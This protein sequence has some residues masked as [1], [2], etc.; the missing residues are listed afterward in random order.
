[1]KFAINFEN[2]G[3]KH[4]L[5]VLVAYAIILF[6]TYSPSINAPL[7]YD[8]IPIIR[9]NL[10]V[11]SLKNPLTLLKTYYL[12]SNYL[13]KG[14]RP[15]TLISF[16]LNAKFFGTSPASFRLINLLLHLANSIILAFFVFLIFDLIGK[17]VSKKIKFLCSAL[18]GGVFLVHPLVGY[19]INLIWKRSTLLAAFFYMIAMVLYIL[20]LKRTKEDKH[21]L[22]VNFTYLTIILLF[23]LGLLCK[24]IVITLPVSLVFLGFALTDKKSFIKELK[25]NWMFYISLLILISVYYYFRIHILGSLVPQSYGIPEPSVN[26]YL[27][28]QFIAILKYINLFFNPTGLSID[29]YIADRGML[30]KKALSLA[31]ILIII[32]LGIS[33]LFFS[34]K[35]KLVGFCMLFYFIVLI[36]TSSVFPLVVY[37][38]ETRAY[39]P[40]ISLIIILVYLTFIILKESDERRVKNHSKHLILVFWVLL[41]VMLTTFSYSRNKLWQDPVLLWKESLER[42][43]NNPRVLDALGSLLAEKGFL[44]QS[45]SLFKRS[46][47]VDPKFYPSY[48]DLGL[49]YIRINKFREGEFYLKKAEKILPNYPL[50]L[51]NLA[52]LYTREGYFKPKEAIKHYVKFKKLWGTKPEISYSLGLLYLKTNSF[53]KAIYEL[54]T[55]HNLVPK[56]NYKR[57]KYLKSLKYN[58]FYNL[59][60][61]YRKNNELKQAQI[62][63]K[64]ALEVKPKEKDPAINLAGI[65]LLMGNIDR[66]TEIFKNILQYD[67]KDRNVLNNLALIYE[68]KGMKEKAYKLYKRILAID[69]KSGNSKK[70]L[71][72]LENSSKERK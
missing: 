10:Y 28:N 62:F 49:T 56:T 50:T 65:Y 55:A 52:F 15:L 9:D 32:G 64:K 5:I 25:S 18:S 33:K 60:N 59:G 37:I 68:K 69:P 22:K 43:P 48:N 17:G 14:Y 24:E 42:A 4:W 26:K 1:M 23:I 41:L 7:I 16:N 35:F 27:G 58:I 11:T 12:D 19:S 36:P 2:P 38:D 44:K 30:L 54:E 71:R 29:H 72:R 21:N 63:Y 8:D 6:V 39:L 3:F 31:T 34:K 20:Q 70:A 57:D 51:Y 13:L 66:G 45:I 47:S 67:P 46:I 53:D 61:A 40:I